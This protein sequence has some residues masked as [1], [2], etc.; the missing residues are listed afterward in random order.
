[1]EISY[2]VVVVFFLT[3]LAPQAV[4][5]RAPP[6]DS[7]PV[8]VDIHHIHEADGGRRRAGARQENLEQEQEQDQAGETSHEGSARY[9]DID[10]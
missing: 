1:M 9:V 4:A 6:I 3:P 8:E 10:L 2:R 5:A 7:S